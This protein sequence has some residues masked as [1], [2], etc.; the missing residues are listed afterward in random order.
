MQVTGFF[1]EP[2]N[3]IFSI[4]PWV[5]VYSNIVQPAI[6]GDSRVPLLKI[7]PL[8][9]SDPQR[10]HTVEFDNFEFSE[11]SLFNFHSLHFEI[12]NHDG[13]FMSGDDENLMLTLLFQKFS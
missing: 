13:S 4:A 12:R 7:I 9:F 10:G 2:P 3:L 5:F 1:P 8:N 6:I 11:L